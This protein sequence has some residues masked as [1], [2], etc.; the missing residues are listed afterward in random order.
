MLVCCH[1]L[2]D[3]KNRNE[4]RIHQGTLK[5]DYPH[6]RSRV[7]WLQ[8]HFWLEFAPAQLRFTWSRIEGTNQKLQLETSQHAKKMWEKSQ[9]YLQ[10][11]QCSVLSKKLSSA[12]HYGRQFL[13]LS[14]MSFW[15]QGS[16]KQMWKAQGLQT[17]SVRAGRNVQT[18][19]QNCLRQLH[20]R[21]SLYPKVWSPIQQD[22]QNSVYS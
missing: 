3:H 20:G 5:T 8:D 13:L 1:A 18:Q 10:T 21:N 15:L 4:R 11:G 7:D 17:R 2:I 6:F 19:N 22:F 16:W 14:R 9:E 12:L